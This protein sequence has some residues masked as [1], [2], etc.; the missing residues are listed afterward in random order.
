MG[1]FEELLDEFNRQPYYEQLKLVRS[2]TATNNLVQ[3]GVSSLSWD[4][5]LRR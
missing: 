1:K 2:I 3:V 5:C 4:G